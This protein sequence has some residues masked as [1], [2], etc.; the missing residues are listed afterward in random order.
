VGEILPNTLHEAI[1]APYCRLS[2]SHDGYANSC[3][4]IHKRD[5]E[6]PD[7]SSAEDYGQFSRPG[8]IAFR[9][10]FHLG[11]CD[12][13]NIEDHKLIAELDSFGFSIDFPPNLKV[14]VFNGSD[15]P[16]LGWH[17]S[18]YGM[19]EPSYSI[20]YSGTLENNHR[21]TIQLEVD[22]L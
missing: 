16:F 14:N 4:T 7:A 20:V 22:A 12:T 13:V 3:S 10:A 5:I 8:G 17:S 9:G 2:A 6:W 11:P 18:V 1:V 15:K 21:H 19:W